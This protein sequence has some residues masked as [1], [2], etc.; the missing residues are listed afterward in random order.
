MSQS[1]AAETRQPAS[2]GA[3]DDPQPK[4]TT[5]KSSP[6]SSSVNG[7]IKASPLAKKL[8]AEK[9]ID[10]ATINGTGDGGRITKADIDNYKEASGSKQTTVW[11][12]SCRIYRQ[13]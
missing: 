12:R 9:G 4:S 2:T 6:S 8:A 10:L 11:L 5:E 1:T 7:R 3:K 13:Y